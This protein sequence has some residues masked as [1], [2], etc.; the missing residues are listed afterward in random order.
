MTSKAYPTTALPP[1]L[2]KYV[3]GTT[4]L[5]DDTIL[6]SKRIRIAREAMDSGV[7]FHT[8]EQYGDA[9]SI[10]GKAFAESRTKIPKLIVKLGNESID[11]L[12]AC[13]QRHISPLGVDRVHLGQLCLGGELARDFA[14]GGKCYDGLKQLQEDGLV[15]HFVLEVF[16]W[17]SEVPLQALRAGHPDGLVGGCI[18]YYNPLQRFASN[19]LWDELQAR[20]VPIVAMRTVAG[21]NVHH[22]RDVPGAAWKP[23]LQERAVEVA[24]IFERSGIPNWSEFCVRFAHSCPLVHATVGATGRSEGLQEFLYASAGT[25]EPLPDDVISEIAAL[26][27]RWSDETDVRAEPWSM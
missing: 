3:Y 7:W 27:R 19:P 9:L 17:T 16:P 1:D 14:N 2:S 5:G 23:Y 18:F 24:P 22:L 11:E 25:I 13:V 10:L 26:Q 21:G 15:E 6:E 20:E 8:S 4:R 12:R